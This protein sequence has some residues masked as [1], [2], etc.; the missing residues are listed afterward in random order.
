MT[1]AQVN[2]IAEKHA[3]L[4]RRQEHRC[5][6]EA[7]RAAIREAAALHEQALLVCECVQNEPYITPVTYEMATKALMTVQGL[8]KE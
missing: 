4:L 7:L 1:E 2:E 6:G 5:I 8:E 3:G